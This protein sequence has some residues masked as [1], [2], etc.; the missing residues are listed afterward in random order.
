MKNLLEY[1]MYKDFKKYIKE[2]QD[3][4][5]F[6]EDPGIDFDEHWEKVDK[7]DP[8]YKYISERIPKQKLNGSENR[9]PYIDKIFKTDD[10]YIAYIYGGENGP[11]NWKNYSDF[12]SELFSNLDHAWVIDLSNDCADDVWTLRIGFDI[13]EGDI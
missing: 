4:H 5:M 8:G 7:E 2:S 12:L 9:Q 11:G 10:H 6:S 3:K 1:T 13:K